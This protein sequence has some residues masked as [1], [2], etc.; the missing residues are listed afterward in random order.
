MWIV[1]VTPDKAFKQKLQ[2]YF[3]WIVDN[4]PDVVFKRTCYVEIIIC[5]PFYVPMGAGNVLSVDCW[6]PARGSI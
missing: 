5:V 3:V 4:L 6:C 2:K 1:D